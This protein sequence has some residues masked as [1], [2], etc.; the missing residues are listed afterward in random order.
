MS[1]GAMLPTDIE[2]Q[3]ERQRDKARRAQQEVDDLEAKVDEETR[4]L[5]LME[6]DVE[7]W[8]NDHAVAVGHATAVRAWLDR[9]VVFGWIDA[10]GRDVVERLARDLEAGSP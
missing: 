5:A 3:L 8:K 6:A 2:A 4:V 10:A 1:V 9:Q 7:R